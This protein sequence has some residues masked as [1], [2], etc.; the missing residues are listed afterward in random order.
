MKILKTLGTHQSSQS[1]DHSHV[2]GELL[3]HLGGASS[4]ASAKLLSA[5]DLD[6][7]PPDP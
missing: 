4:P 3:G 5:D 2:M 1:S 6:N 7:L